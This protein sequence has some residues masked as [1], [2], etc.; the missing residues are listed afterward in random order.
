MAYWADA[1]VVG[2]LAQRSPI[3]KRTIQQFLSH[4]RGLRV[5]DINLRGWTPEIRKTVRETLK[6]VDV[7]KVNELELA[8]LQEEFDSNAEP[9]HFL[10]QLIAEFELSLAALSLGAEGCLLT[11]G[12]RAVR[13]PGIPVSVVDTTGCGDAFTAGLVV[14]MLEDASLEEMAQFAN[15]V[16]AFV[17]TQKGASPL[18]SREDLEAFIQIQNERKVQ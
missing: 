16:G 18:Y 12:T 8:K 5:Y 17:A 2:T 10:N 15:A 4:A 11:D 6:K 13:V 9:L 1:V 14:K 3:S 7:V